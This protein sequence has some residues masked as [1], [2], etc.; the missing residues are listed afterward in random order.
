[1]SGNNGPAVLTG[2]ARLAP[3]NR[4][5]VPEA[6][7]AEKLVDLLVERLGDRIVLAVQDQM[8]LVVLP[9]IGQIQ[10]RVDNLAGDIQEAQRRRPAQ[11]S[12]FEEAVQRQARNRVD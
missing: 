1:M 3:T 7:G 4:V 6:P 2:E 10:A 8:N 12:T 9:R 5:A 11:A